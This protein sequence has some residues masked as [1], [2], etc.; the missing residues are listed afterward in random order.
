MYYQYLKNFD[1]V[2]K[3]FIWKETDGEA[4]GLDEGIILGS[5]L[6]EVWGSTL[7]SDDGTELVSYDGSFDGSN[8][9]KPVG[10]LLS[11][12]LG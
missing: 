7:G 1:H 5:D 2:V 10:V 12:S 9:S 8:D 6:G 3:W 4:L 11:D